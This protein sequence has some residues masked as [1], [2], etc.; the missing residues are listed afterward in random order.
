[1]ANGAEYGVGYLVSHERDRIESEYVLNEGG[2]ASVE[3]PTGSYYL[4]SVGE[5]EVGDYLRFPRKE[6]PCLA[7]LVGQEPL[8]GMA[9]V[10][11]GI[12]AYTPEIRM[13]NDMLIK[14][15]RGV[16]AARYSG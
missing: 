6:L 2:G 3:T 10:L 11:A 16:R 8:L 7:A 4:V 5:K 15:V 1:M 12:E 9:A 13:D 14:L